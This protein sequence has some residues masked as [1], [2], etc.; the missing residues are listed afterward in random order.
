MA[1]IIEIQNAFDPV[2]SRN[3]HHCPNGGTVRQWLDAKP[4][5]VEFTV[6]TVCFLN[7][8]AIMRSRW[9][10][11]KLVDRDVV[12][13][14]PQPG[15]WWFVVAVIAIIAVT[16]VVAR[17]FIDIPQVAGGAADIAEGDSVFSLKGHRNQARPGDPIQVPYG[18][19]R[20]WP[21]YA[22]RPYSRYEN[23]D[24]YLYSLFCIGQGTYTI[25]PADIKI[26]D[27][28]IGDYAD[29]TYE[30]Y[31][32]GDLV[33]MFPDSVTTSTAV[34]G[35]E[36]EGQNETSPTSNV[37]GPFILN[38][39][40]EGATTK[41]EIDYSFPKGLYYSND[42]GGITSLQVTADFSYIEHDGSGNNLIGAVWTVFAAID[43]SLATVTPQRFTVDAAV[44]SGYY[45]VKAERTNNA[46]M[47]HRAG[48]TLRWD[49]LK[50]IHPD[51]RDYG[52][53][54]MMGVR[55]KATNNLNNQS[56]TA[57]NIVSTRHLPIWNG[58]TWNARAETRELVWAFCDVLR[59]TYGP[60]VADELIDKAGLLAMAPLGNFDWVFDSKTTV[61]EALK[62]IAR[63]RRGTPVM[64]GSLIS[65]VQDVAGTDPVGVFNQENIIRDSFQLEEQLYTNDEYD[66]VEGTYIDPITGEKMTSDYILP[67]LVPIITAEGREARLQKVD[68]PGLNGP[69]DTWRE[70]SYITRS[71][72]FLRQNV[73]WATGLEGLIPQF[74]DLVAVTHSLPNWGQGGM[75]VALTLVSGITYEVE[76]DKAP[77]VPSGTPY[78][79][80]RKKDGDMSAVWLVTAVSGSSTKF[81]FNMVTDV[82]SDFETGDN[83]ERAYWLFGEIDTYT[84]LVKVD[85]AIPQ[86]EDQ[87]VI[88]GK[89][90]SSKPYDN[91]GLS[92]S[93][94]ALAELL[95]VPDL[96]AVASVLVRD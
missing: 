55:A 34:D 40:V 81:T 92:P 93:S 58:T 51:T 4:G 65:M 16:T 47:S 77:E 28:A 74:G 91:D 56:R 37:Q 85:S 2:G 44:P 22:A 12:A 64:N 53:V 31:G 45:K 75:I 35:L 80:L 23:N 60:Q 82:A 25:N 87:V 39:T 72:H 46:N 32:P 13:F 43:H 59:G 10:T 70:A 18:K 84:K 8:K 96:P 89:V 94:V 69:T 49:G 3:V 26:G 88:T 38:S 48:D 6:P 54:T 19:N 62:V 68:L 17:A 30:I 15:F 73:Q 42:S 79:A 83:V 29:T 78:I 66:G 95:A 21:P 52:D 20:T 33:D 67:E 36:L 41:L 7:G 1:L 11:H 61:W 86:G 9:I 50:C 14:V 71:R 76:L 27:T 24:Q 5:F 57:F 90:Y 63:C